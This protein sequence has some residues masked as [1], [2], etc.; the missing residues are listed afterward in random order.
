MSIFYQLGIF[1]MQVVLKFGKG[2]SPKWEKMLKG[3]EN[4]FESM[5][6]FRKTH[7]SPLA[8]FHVASLG[9]YEQ[10]KPVIRAFKEKHPFWAI[11]VTF[12]S[13][14]GYEIVVK[15]KQLWVDHIQYLPF[16]SKG[17]AQ[18]FVEILNP[19]VGFFVKY[20]L[21][22][23]HIMEAKRR[24]IPLFLVAAAF[25]KDQVYFKWYG[26]FFR[27]ALQ[28]FDWIFT[29]TEEQAAL[30][31]SI[32][33]M[34]LSRA[35]DPRY[36]NV[37]AIALA[38]KH[39]PE[40]QPRHPVLVVGSAWQEDM[41]ILLPFLQEDNSYQVIIAPHEIRPDKIREWEKAIG[42]P[43]LLYSELVSSGTLEKNWEVLFIDNIGMLSSLYQFARVAY[44][45][46][47]L[48]K[49]LHNILE[50]L[51]FGV[52]VVF[53]KVKREN[54]FL[55]AAISQE[56]GCGIAVN[57]PEALS[58]AFNGLESGEAYGKACKAAKKLVSDNLGSA[59]KIMEKV[60][61]FIE[62]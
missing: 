10:A 35:G 20:D 18:R 60:S 40:I 46:G 32:G 55:E 23:N 43:S 47:A 57:T 24:N 53:G 30:A 38:P 33:I 21:W 31:R 37:T 56:Y 16:D 41:D 6:K 14:S 49:G 9:E 50:A 34:Q 36:D 17:N 4:L 26:G 58:A 62:Q 8:W 48:G 45:G 22:A 13:P 25:R 52:P 11:C 51:A 59:A 44:V 3:R 5:K 7:P 54:K 2:F 29:Q 19:Q 15:K 61:K 42:R 39:F 1:L 12:F 27:N 28:Q